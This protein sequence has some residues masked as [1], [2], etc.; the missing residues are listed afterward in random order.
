MQV[1][2]GGGTHTFNKYLAKSL[3]FRF[4]KVVLRCPGAYD[5]R[6]IQYIDHITIAHGPEAIYPNFVQMAKELNKLAILA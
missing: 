2:G 1:E 3:S 5:L 4:M 6:F